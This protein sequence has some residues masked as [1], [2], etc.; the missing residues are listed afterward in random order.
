MA[1]LPKYS[2]VIPVF[3]SE[4]SLEE[5]YSGIQALFAERQERFE[6]V[7]VDDR[8]RDNSWEVLKKL[9]A[10][11]TDTIT[12]IRLARNFGQHNATLCGLGFARGELIV[13]I[14]DDLQT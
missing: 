8:S 12:A 4:E 5:L 13:T 11:H 9:K 2:I 14:D 10:A 7:F 1:L 3:N 6:V